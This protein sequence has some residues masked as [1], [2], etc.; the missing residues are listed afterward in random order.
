MS[1][2]VTG[3][4]GFIG[5]HTCVELL[6]AGYDLVVFDNFSNSKPSVIDKIAD[7]SGRGF[8][9]YHTDMNDKNALKR[10][11][12]DNQIECVIH[13]A[14][15]KAVG[16]S[17][18]KPL[19][20]Y[21]NNI[22]GTL[23]LL[24][25]M[26]D[27]GVKKIVFSSSAT[28]YGVPRK[29]PITEDEPLSVT[30]PYGRTKLMIEDIL[31]DLYVSDDSWSIIMLRYFNPVGGHESGL[32]CEDP[33]G[34]PNNL[35]PRILDTVFGKQE[36]MQVFGNDYPTVDGTGVRDYI[37]V[38]DLAKGHVKAVERLMRV[39]EIQAIN[40]GTGRGYSVLELIKTFEQVNNVSIP[41]EFS[42]RRPGDVAECFAD[43]KKAYD[44]L[45][46]KAELGVSEM[47]RDSYKARL[48]LMQGSDNA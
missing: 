42:P 40:L 29:V 21:Q 41:V 36:K 9:F 16:E 46:W 32:L 22:T 48:M 15:Y 17:V 31:R 2:L 24:E 23:N 11:F 6:E 28:V 35:M 14:G 45:G 1:I 30:N 19:M 7:I 44:L 27:A 37:H 20:Y 43:T 18:E 34:I 26:T 38:Q 10:I 39:N 33:N 47:C 8:K 5:S 25:A 12:A 3:G 4:T 13:F